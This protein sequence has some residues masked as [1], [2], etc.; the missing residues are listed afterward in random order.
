MGLSNKSSNTKYVKV[1]Y[2]NGDKDNGAPSF[3]IQRKVNSKWEIVEQGNNLEGKIIGIEKKSYEYRGKDQHQ[4]SVKVQSSGEDYALELGYGYYSRNVLNSLSGIGDL[5]GKN[6]EFSIY[7]NKDGFVSI[8]TTCD[9]EKIDWELEAKSLPG[10]DDP[11]WLGSFDY[12]INK[13]KGCLAPDE[14]VGSGSFETVDE[15]VTEAKPESNEPAEDDDL[16]F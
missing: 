7:R 8:Y 11:K 13:I 4:F 1:V 14:N 15:P 2:E 16:P 12:F 9:G 5:S 3:G 6:V 10:A